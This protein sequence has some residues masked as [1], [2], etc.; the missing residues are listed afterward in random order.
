MV[1][2]KRIYDKVEKD[3]GIRVLV[4]KLWP[5]GLKKEEIKIDLWLKRVAP[6]TELRRW[7]SHDPSRW[8]EFCEKYKQELT[9]DE[10]KRK[11]LMELIKL[12]SRGN[13]TLIYSAK[14]KEH[15][16]AV[17]LKKLVESLLK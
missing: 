10:E 17:V 8:K 13:L 12:A 2:T 3:D 16:N 9:K 7:F 6:S 15:N 1:K 11:A 5:R 14:D 4:D